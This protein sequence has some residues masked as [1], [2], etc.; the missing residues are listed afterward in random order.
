MKTVYLSLGS[1][2]GDREGT[3]GAA[4]Q[5]L[6]AEGI[7]ITAR[8]SLY[9]TEPQ[10]ARNQ[11][12]FLN[13]AAACETSLLPQQLLRVTQRV[14]R[15]LGRMRDAS[16]GAKGPRTIDIDILLFAGCIIDTPAVTIPHPRILGRRF[17]LEPLFEIAPD[18]RHPLT[19]QLLSG[20]L[21]LVQSQQLR[22]LKSD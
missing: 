1:N 13:I 20:F 15:E 16:I 2:I 10:D 11:P 3:L 14:E 21:P 17:V 4:L 12:W 19:G 7:Q 18:L 8:S 5:K 9:E 22:K 6:A